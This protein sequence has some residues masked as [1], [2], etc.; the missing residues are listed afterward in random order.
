MNATQPLSEK[1]KSRC[2]AGENMTAYK[3][4]YGKTFSGRRGKKALH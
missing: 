3:N 4:I 2:A 1:S